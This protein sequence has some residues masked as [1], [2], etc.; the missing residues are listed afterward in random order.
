MTA[1][2]PTV[3]NE[4]ISEVLLSRQMKLAGATKVL[5]LSRLSMADMNIIDLVA[6]AWLAHS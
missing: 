2:S 4:T 6:N 1:I 5:Y 3:T